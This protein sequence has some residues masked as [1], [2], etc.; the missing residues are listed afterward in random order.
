MEGTR[1][2]RVTVPFEDQLNTALGGVD[3]GSRIDMFAIV[4]VSVDDDADENERFAKGQRRLATA[5]T[6]FTGEPVHYL[7]VAVTIS[8]LSLAQHDDLA[9]PGYIASQIAAVLAV[10]PGRIP[11]GLDYPRLSIS[12]SAALIEGAQPRTQ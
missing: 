10:R 7:S 11:R 4:I 5:R 12:V 3:F 8:P 1:L 2:V 9:L 6:P